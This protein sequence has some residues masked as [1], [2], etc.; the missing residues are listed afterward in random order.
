M[1][2]IDD[3]GGHKYRLCV[4]DPAS[5]KR[6]RLSLTV[7]VPEELRRAPVKAK[8][9][10]D[11]ELA[12]FEEQVAEGQI[13]RSEKQTLKQ[14]V[15]TWEK[16][17]AEQNMGEYTQKLYL[18]VFE[19]YLY[20]EFGDIRMDQIKTLHLVTFFAELKLKNGKP[21]A[22]NTKLN[23]YKA[24]KSLFDN[25]YKWKLIA[26]N[27][28]EGVD[29]P[30]AQKKEKRTMRLRKKSYTRS[31]A[32]DVVTA[33]YALPE[34]WRL[35]F[36]GVLLGGFRRGEMLALQWSYVD[37]EAGGIHVKRQI[38]QDKDGKKVDTELKT[39]ES[40]AFV[41]MPKWY[42]SDLKKYKREWNKEKLNCKEWVGGDSQYV[43]HSGAGD[44]YF[45]NTP[46]RTWS[47][48][49]K[50]TGLPKI[51]LHDLRHTTAMVLRESG[52]D[53]KTIQERL[54]HTKLSTTADIYM[55]E[56]EL[57]SRDAAD[58]LESLK[59]NFSQSAT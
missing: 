11:L 50:K 16:G 48:F 43:F 2:Y 23:I 9:W 12:K 58:R 56:S 41:P 33:L 45:P 34:R 47:D 26:K 17:Y 54:R 25:A 14:F 19:K 18:Y 10:L 6:K 55:E 22:T 40:E 57:V 7:E 59:P 42:M 30:S 3:L 24:T 29:R 8:R 31:E 13:I 35:Y 52:A 32:A 28:I 15:P 38:S 27:P 39:D 44:F 5:A 1:A 49:I 36:L 53:L 51:R 37:N 20:P 46:T 4:Q 21:M